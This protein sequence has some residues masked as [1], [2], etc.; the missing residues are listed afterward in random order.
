MNIAVVCGGISPER[1]V[2]LVGGLAAANALEHNGHTVRIIDPAFGSD[3][4][5][6][7]DQILVNPSELPSSDI[8]DLPKQR[9]LDCVQSS[10][11]DGIDKAFL[12]IHGT[13]GED[14]IFQALLEA[15]GIPYTGSKVM[16][17]ALAMNKLASKVMFSAVGIQTPIWIAAVKS[18]GHLENPATIQDILEE[19]PGSIVIKPNDQGSTVG[20][21]ILHNP[22]TETIY[23]ALQ[24]AGEYSDIVLIEEFIDGRELTVAVL[25]DEA[26]P[27]IEIV[28]EG[29]FYDY[30]RKYT[31]GFTEYHCPADLSEDIS[32]FVQNLAI[33]AHHAL[34][35]TAYSRVDFR[36][37]EDNVPYCLEVNTIPG[38]SS[39]SLVPM[40][41]KEAGIDFNRLCEMIIELS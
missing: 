31:K 40:A 2:S 18:K 22:T 39:T 3:S 33:S 16:S 14:G 7:K 28:P 30:K 20:M 17:S 13:N 9:L 41:A 38:F 11:F 35:C 4:I 6:S 8:L 12:L 21:T 10:A 37:N 34:G 29:G 25:G 15:K 1:N 5:R 24:L 23:N 36:L 26:L 27:I 32:S 19:I